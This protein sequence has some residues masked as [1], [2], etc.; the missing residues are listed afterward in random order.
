MIKMSSDKNIDVFTEV[1]NKDRNRILAIGLE[2]QKLEHEKEIIFI[3]LKKH[4]QELLELRDRDIRF[5]QH[6]QT[7]RD[8]IN[9]IYKKMPDSRMIDSQEFG[10][11]IP[12]LRRC[13]NEIQELEEK[14]FHD[15]DEQVHD[16]YINL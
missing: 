9:A 3:E 12:E 6:E 2:I 1:I 5:S 8:K 10:M 13:Q 4:E 11:Y 16:I 7:I 15:C 14:G